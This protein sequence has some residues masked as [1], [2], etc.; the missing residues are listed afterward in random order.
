MRY[1][2]GMEGI[3][4]LRILDLSNN[5]VQDISGLKEAENLEGVCLT[6]IAFSESSM[7]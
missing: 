4:K 5:L 6:G 2:D 1:I 7:L 3:K